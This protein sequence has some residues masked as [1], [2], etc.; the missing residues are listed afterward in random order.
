MQVARNKKCVTHNTFSSV[1]K[2]VIGLLGLIIAA[3]GVY[4]SMVNH[5]D[6]DPLNLCDSD[7]GKVVIKT[8]P[9]GSQ[10]QEIKDSSAN[11]NVYCF[12]LRA[13]GGVPC[14]VGL[15]LALVWLMYMWV[16][17]TKRTEQLSAD[18]MKKLKEIQLDINTRVIK[19]HKMLKKQ[20]TEDALDDQLS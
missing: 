2:A 13:G 19:E 10:I 8:M 5:A 7:S 12:A 9:D 15:L 18:E 3:V 17:K 16:T 14:G 11:A 20:L 6:L 1:W 4:W